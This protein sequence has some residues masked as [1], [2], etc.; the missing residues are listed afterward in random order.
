M[1]RDWKS[2]TEELAHIG[3]MLLA[4][5]ICPCDRCLERTKE[6]VRYGENLIKEVEAQKRQPMNPIGEKHASGF[7]VIAGGK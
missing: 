2:K 6:L 1:A 7:S 5:A 3:P 4:Y